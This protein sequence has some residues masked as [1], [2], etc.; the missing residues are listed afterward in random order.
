LVF[1][2]YRW[3]A[4]MLLLALI[5]GVQAAHALSLPPE[6]SLAPAFE[7]VSSGLW[8]LVFL[9]MALRLWKNAP[10]ARF[11]ALYALLLLLGYRILHSALFAR[12]DY[13]RQR[14]P[15]LLAAG[16]IFLAACGIYL[17]RQKKRDARSDIP[18]MD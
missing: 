8:T 14:L 15:F 6:I 4:L 17:L 2:P 12:A 5:Q 1:R 13:D 16:I 10:R 9:W 11:H 18:E 7:F 3:M